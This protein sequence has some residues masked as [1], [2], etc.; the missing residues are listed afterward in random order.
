M[1]SNI[2]IASQPAHL[3]ICP[4]LSISI[5]KNLFNSGLAFINKHAEVCANWF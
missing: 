2:L 5:Y 3:Q 4:L 1:S